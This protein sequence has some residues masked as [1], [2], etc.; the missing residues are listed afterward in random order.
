MRTA[1]PERVAMS[2]LVTALVHRLQGLVETA[3][4]LRG[5]HPQA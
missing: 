4:E 5:G 1:S 2:G 3:L